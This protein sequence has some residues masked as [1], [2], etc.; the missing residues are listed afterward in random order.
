MKMILVALLDHPQPCVQ[1]AAAEA[2]GEAVHTFPLAG[3]SCLPLLMYKLRRSVANGIQ[4]MAFPL[5]E[6]Q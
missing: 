2:C 4:G 3:I 1:A 6:L 5:D